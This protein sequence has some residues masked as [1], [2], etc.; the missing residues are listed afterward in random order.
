MLS[1]FYV[2]LIYSFQLRLKN[3]LILFGLNTQLYI[4]EIFKMFQ[5][6]P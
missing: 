2:L 1:D 4:Q 6:M 5:K 3:Y